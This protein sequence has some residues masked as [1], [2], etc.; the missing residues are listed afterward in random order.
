MSQPILRRPRRV[1]TVALVT[2]CVQPESGAAGWAS[3]EAASLARVETRV[4]IPPRPAPAF[5]LLLQSN[6]PRV[7]VSQRATASI[8]EPFGAV[9]ACL[10]SHLC[11][12]TPMSGTLSRIRWEGGKH[13][14]YH[15][16]DF[17][18]EWIAI[19]CCPIV[20]TDAKTEGSRS[21]STLT[22]DRHVTP[23]LTVAT[24]RVIGLDSI[25]VQELDECPH[26]F[27]Y[28]PRRAGGRHDQ[29]GIRSVAHAGPPF[30]R[31]DVWRSFANAGAPI[32]GT[33]ARIARTTRRATM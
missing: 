8:R 26:A 28:P 21:L 3:S 19:V 30:H 22:I 31:R 14:V 5:R 10:T 7:P 2:Q 33:F 17:A 23:S 9:A 25:V 4:R 18:D 12:P 16:I 11:L 15:A 20:L 1:S 13:D 27:V 32:P 24:A 29:R 6:T